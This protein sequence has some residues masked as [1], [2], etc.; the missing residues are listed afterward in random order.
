MY[1]QFFWCCSVCLFFFIICFCIFLLRVKKKIE[2]KSKRGFFPLFSFCSFSKLV[3]K[4]KVK[5]LR[6]GGGCLNGTFFC[7]ILLRF[8]AP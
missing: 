8:F 7:F 1:L 5:L 2:K 6:I 3:D 4:R